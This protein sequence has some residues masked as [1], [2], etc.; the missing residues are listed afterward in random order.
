MSKWRFAVVILLLGAIFGPE[1]NAGA[2]YRYKFV[3]QRNGHV[4]LWRTYNGVRTSPDPAIDEDM[5]TGDSVFVF[6]DQEWCNDTDVKWEDA[7]G[8][9]KSNF[10]GQCYAYDRFEEFLDDHPGVLHHFTLTALD[11]REI[12]CGLDLDAW[13]HYLETNPAPDP[14]ATYDFFGGLCPDLPGYFVTETASGEPFTGTCGSELNCSLSLSVGGSVPTLS[15][16]ALGLLILMLAAITVA[17]CRR[18]ERA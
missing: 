17:L 7:G 14:A 5:V 13:Y 4:W 11:G 2:S 12:D 8:V 9:K 10:V 1:V 18:R 16:P 15:L 6:G 3:A